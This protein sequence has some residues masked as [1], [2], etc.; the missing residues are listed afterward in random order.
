MAELGSCVKV[1]LPAQARLPVCNKPY[2]FWGRKATFEEEEEEEAKWPSD[3]V[4]I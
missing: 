2:G 4:K 3:R 1:E